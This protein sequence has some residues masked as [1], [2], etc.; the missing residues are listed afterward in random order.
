MNGSPANINVVRK[1]LTANYEQ[2]VTIGRQTNVPETLAALN[3]MLTEDGF[4]GRMVVNY[5]QGGVTNIVTEQVAHIREG[6]E[7]DKVL[8]PEFAK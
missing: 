3:K 1:K 2:V 8:E 5:N 7:A 4:T 6:S